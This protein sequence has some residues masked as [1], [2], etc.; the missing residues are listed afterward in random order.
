MH[1]HTDTRR[2]EAGLRSRPEH[3]PEVPLAVAAREGRGSI[4]TFSGP[5]QL[6]D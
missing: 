1:Q 3:Q 2:L 4:R 5:A 6:R